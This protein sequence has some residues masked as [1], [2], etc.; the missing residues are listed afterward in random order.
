MKLSAATAIL[1]LLAGM[2]LSSPAE[3]RGRQNN[4]RDEVKPRGRR[5]NGGQDAKRD[6]GDAVVYYRIKYGRKGRL[7]IRSYRNRELILSA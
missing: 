2:A 1:V 5:R 7:Y 4:K 6:L 3:P